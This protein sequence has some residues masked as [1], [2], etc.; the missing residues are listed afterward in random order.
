MKHPSKESNEY[1]KAKAKLIKKNAEASEMSKLQEALD[2]EG[3]DIEVTGKV[4]WEPGDDI[5][6]NAHMMLQDEFLQNAPEEEVQKHYPYMFKATDGTMRDM[7][8]TAPELFP[9]EKKTASE[10]F[11]ELG[12]MVR[13]MAK[14]GKEMLDQIDDLRFRVEKLEAHNREER[15]GKGY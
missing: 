13:K 15:H 5:K 4:E 9:K 10:K 6:N 3:L 14:A 11:Y 2:R 12:D 1:Y 7:R 8:F